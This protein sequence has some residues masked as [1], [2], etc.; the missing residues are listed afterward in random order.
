MET[1]LIITSTI[2]YIIALITYFFKLKQSFTYYLIYFAAT[3]QLAVLVLRS[4][5]SGHVPFTNSYETLLLFPFLISL[6]LIFWRDQITYVHRWSVILLI[7]LLNSIAITLSGSLKIARPLMP[8]LNSFWLYFHVPSY[9]FGYVSM[10]IAFIYSII[11]IVTPNRENNNLIKRLDN[12]IKIAFFFLNVGLITG[13][14]W[15][16][17]S[18]GNYWSWDPKE[19][20]ALINILVLSFYFHLQTPTTRKKAAIVI[21]TFLTLIFTYWGVNFILAG[22]HSYA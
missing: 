7:V 13:A 15:A 2:L 21:I 8:A 19:V 3:L 1:V 11:L 14:I 6:R 22:L 4:V 9:F 10:S 17:V 18:W 12:E 20:W 5:V 16:Y